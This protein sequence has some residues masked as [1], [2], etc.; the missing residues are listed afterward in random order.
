M[1]NVSDRSIKEFCLTVGYSKD[2]EEFGHT[3]LSS[4]KEAVD[5]SLIGAPISYVW[6]SFIGCLLG[7]STKWGKFASTLSLTASRVNDSLQ[8]TFA[9]MNAGINRSPNIIVHPNHPTGI[10]HTPPSLAQIALSGLI[11]RIHPA[12]AADI[13]N[14]GLPEGSKINER[15]YHEYSLASS[16]VGVALATL[17]IAG[18]V[19]AR[20]K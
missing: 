15:A 17:G 20:F 18:F 7:D 13:V 10:I 14:E 12:V 1:V 16:V 6:G 2:P 3:I 9:G 8:L 19:F 5:S 11:S 4:A